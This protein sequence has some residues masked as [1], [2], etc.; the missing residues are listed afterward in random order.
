MVKKESLLFK[1]KTKSQHASF[2]EEVSGIINLN[3]CFILTPEMA[4]AIYFKTKHQGIESK[5]HKDHNKKEFISLSSQKQVNFSIKNQGGKALYFIV[6][7]TDWMLSG[8]LI[9]SHDDLFG[10]FWELSSTMEDDFIV[11]DNHLSNS[12][13]CSGDRMNDKITDYNITVK[14]SDFEI[15][16]TA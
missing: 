15:I 13:L 10:N 9:I 11:L 5:I 4:Q 3:N 2:I 7:P 8:G 16:C 1:K 6:L 12:I 14:G